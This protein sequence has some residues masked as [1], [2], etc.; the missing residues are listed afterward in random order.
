M[1]NTKSAKK[2]MRQS[3]KRQ[4][5]NRQERSE[6]RS[7]VKKVR[8]AETKDAAEAALKSAETLIDRAARKHLVHPNK[9][10]RT[11]SRLHKAAKAKS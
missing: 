9:A 6:L 7:A 10:A 5:K 4:E 3:E 8:K 1:P 2:R 11:K